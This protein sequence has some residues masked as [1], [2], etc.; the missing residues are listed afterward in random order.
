MSQNETL[1]AFRDL[2]WKL[3]GNYQCAN[4]F[5]VLEKARE[6]VDAL[7]SGTW[8]KGVMKRLINTKIS[9]TRVLNSI[10]DELR[11]TA[12]WLH[13]SDTRLYKKRNLVKSDMRE[14]GLLTR[15][16]SSELI[17]K[18]IGLWVWEIRHE[19]IPDLHKCLCE[20]FQSNPDKIRWI[21]VH[22]WYYLWVSEWSSQE[23][24]HSALWRI[25]GSS[26]QYWESGHQLVSSENLLLR[27][28]LALANANEGLEFEENV[29]QNLKK[30]I[31]WKKQQKAKAQRE[32]E[33]ASQRKWEQK[34]RALER[35]KAEKQRVYV[36][37]SELKWVNWRRASEY[38]KTQAVTWYIAESLVEKINFWDLSWDDE[39]LEMSIQLWNYCLAYGIFWYKKI[40][41]AAL[42]HMWVEGEQ[43]YKSIG[44]TLPW[45][46][47]WLVTTWYL[48]AKGI[49]LKY[50]VRVLNLVKDFNNSKKEG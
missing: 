1:Q 34:G 36:W 20:K 19:D 16:H 21:I 49:N 27:I 42:C 22:I 31:S 8:P 9:I 15:Q 12:L 4:M 37:L 38:I 6:H 50:L 25:T 2:A 44:M 46:T 11:D 40:F 48:N 26:R 43:T 17:L 10:W 14:I 47:N 3:E 29:Y 28:L 39:L 24:N 5:E 41:H 7:L 30:I 35:K 23:L 45:N 33:R 32:Q 13:L 18:R